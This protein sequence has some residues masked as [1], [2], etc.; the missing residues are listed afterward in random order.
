MSRQKTTK[1]NQLLRDWP[2]GTVATQKWLSARGVSRQLTNRYV[3]SGWLERIGTGALI[4]AGA[5]VGW[6]GGVYALQTQLSLQV[7][8]AGV[9]AL[10]LRGFGHYLPLGRSY[11]VHVF[12]QP[13][14]RLPE[15]FR[16]H[17]WE[18]EV[19]YSCPNLFAQRED[20]G[21][22]DLDRGAFSVRASAPERAILE[23][24]HLATTNHAMD[25]AVELCEGLT[26]LRPDLVQHLLESC[27][28]AKVKRFFL[29]AAEHCDHPW[30]SRV[31]TSSIDLGAGKR[32]LYPGGTFSSKYR[33]TVPDTGDLP[34]V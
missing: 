17:S 18:V 8:V 31:D 23:V 19:S 14:Q 20:S 34:N 16:Q 28:S 27:R 33:I 15:W 24:M 25:H 3:S 26:T 7:H 2:V 29:W 4:R 13:R 5:T 12:G 6:L 1:I 30:L 11:Q 22:I 9:T 32:S 21:F 10:M